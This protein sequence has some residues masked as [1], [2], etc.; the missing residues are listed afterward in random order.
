MLD[1]KAT[2]RNSVLIASVAILL[3]LLSYQSWRPAQLIA[4]GSSELGIKDL[5]LKVKKELA[6]T[7]R[8]R[9]INEAALFKLRDFE[10]EVNFIVKTRHAAS[11]KVD[12][13]VVA[14]GADTEIGTERIQRI[15]LRMDAHIQEPGSQPPLPWPPASNTGKEVTIGPTPPA[16]DGGNKP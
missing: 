12:Y 15:K 10:L 4:T 13:E 9:P 8:D 11:G 7:E 2:P 16:A 1:L 3:L 6:E 14:V 5:I